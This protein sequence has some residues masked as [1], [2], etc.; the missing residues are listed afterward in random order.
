M[1]AEAEHAIFR[2][3]I[4]L[5]ACPGPI[6]YSRDLHNAVGVLLGMKNKMMSSA[7]MLSRK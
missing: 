4:E 5:C 7:A 1:I 3:Y 2:R 6:E